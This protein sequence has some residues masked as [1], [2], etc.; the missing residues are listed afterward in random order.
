NSDAASAQD[1][2]SYPVG[3]LIPVEGEINSSAARD[4]DWFSFTLETTSIV[5][6]ET[7]RSQNS[8]DDFDT[9][10]WLYD[11]DEN[12]IANNDDIDVFGGNF[13]SRIGPELL[14]AGTYLVRVENSSFFAGN[15]QSGLYRLDIQIQDLFCQPGA[16]ACGDDGVTVT[17]CD[18]GLAFN[19][20][21]TC[22][23]ACDDSGDRVV[24]T[25]LPVPTDLGSF[26][27]DL[28]I[29]TTDTLAEEMDGETVINWYTFESTDEL[30]LELILSAVEDGPD[31]DTRVFLCDPFL[32]ETEQCSYNNNIDNADDGAEELWTLWQ[33][34]APA[35]VYY[36]GIETWDGSGGDFNVDITGVVAED[37]DTPEGAN[38]ITLPYE[39]QPGSIAYPDDPDWYTFT[40]DPGT[41]VN[42]NLDV[43]DLID[44]AIVL[45]DEAQ[46]MAGTCQNETDELAF[47][48][49]GL[50]GESEAIIGFELTNGGT[51]YIQVLA[52]FGGVG[53]YTLSVVESD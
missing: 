31:L 23:S 29:S 34:P 35:G 5:T 12:Q 28:P 44:V 48:D 17:R 18:V 24:C 30:L 37:D 42:I 11:A 8:P 51:Y 52:F 7:L 25:D 41:F 13:F 10:M 15:G 22:S 53:D 33:G 36:L 38:A 46:I 3:T 4:G 6:L 40:A 26:P 1:L 43:T 47:A 27:A 16:I 39:A 49:I 50:D 45:C 20:V 32:F 9:E 14:E 21:N 19:D 2:G